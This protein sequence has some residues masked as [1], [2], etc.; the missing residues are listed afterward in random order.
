MTPKGV[1][2]VL[3]DPQGRVVANASD[4]EGGGSAGVSRKE[5]QTWRAKRACAVDYVVGSCNGY[6]AAVIRD[7]YPGAE[8]VVNKLVSEH[9]F[10]QHV[11]E[12]GYDNDQM[13]G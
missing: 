11:I 10:R 13:E 1:T 12:H 5:A 6:M 7:G 9:G 4:F 8:G 2:V 3:T